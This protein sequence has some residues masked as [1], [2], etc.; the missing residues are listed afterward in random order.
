MWVV[1]CWLLVIRGDSPGPQLPR[2]EEP[3][4]TNNEPNVGC[5]LLVIR[6]DLPGPHLP[7]AEEPQ[8]TNN[9][10]PTTEESAATVKKQ[11]APTTIRAA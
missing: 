11:D 4:T 2:A 1:C 5:L 8:T 6:G 7:R 9:E 3:Q 10:Q